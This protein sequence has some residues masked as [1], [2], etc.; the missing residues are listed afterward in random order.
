MKRIIYTAV[1]LITCASVFGIADYINAQKKGALADYSDE[2][3][4]TEAVTEKKIEK[5]AVKNETV[6]TDT[7]KETVKEFKASN[8]IAKV[9]VKDTRYTERIPNLVVT[10][11]VK[12]PL[13]EKI[14][15]VTS[16]LQSATTDTTLQ[17]ESKRKLSMEMFSRAPIREKKIKRK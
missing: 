8:K 13:P 1:A 5:A 12:D 2:V 4:T 10:E 14:D 16:L 7:K 17:V 15:P 9:N 11:P 6:L 3:Q